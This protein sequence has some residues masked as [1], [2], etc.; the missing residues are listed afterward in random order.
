MEAITKLYNWRP[1]IVRF[2]PLHL[3]ALCTLIIT[4]KTINNTKNY[5]CSCNIQ[6]L[7]NMMFC[8]KLNHQEV[9]TPTYKNIKRC[10]LQTWKFTALS[11]H[12]FNNVN[13]FVKISG[14]IRQN[15]QIVTLWTLVYYDSLFPD[16]PAFES[17]HFPDGFY[18]R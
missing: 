6:S 18:I 13:A 3:V 2:T 7:L 12:N 4:V 9:N 15:K 16:L 5:F 14:L 11:F 1:N 17:A 10:Q 8:Y